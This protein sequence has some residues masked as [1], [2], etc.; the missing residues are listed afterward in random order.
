MQEMRGN[1]T[2][3]EI[4]SQPSTW[5]ETLSYLKK[6]WE[7]KK[8]S[9]QDYDQVIVSGC[10]STYYLSIWAA[11]FLQMNTGI[12]CISLPGSELWYSG[13]NWIKPYQKTLLI[14]VSRS[15]K[16]TETLHAMD[17]FLRSKKGDALAITCYADSPLAKMTPSAIITS[18]GMEHSIAQ[19]RSFTNMMWP[20]IFM[21]S[22]NISDDQI[23]LIEQSARRM[24]ED[25]QSEALRIG[26]NPAFE[27]FFFLGNGP[28]YGLA[29]EVMLKM[30]EMSLS[31]SEAYHFLEFRHGPM[32]MVNDLSLVVGFTDGHSLKFE[33]PVFHDMQKLGA[34]TLSV[35]QHDYS[36]TESHFSFS[37]NGNLPT[38]LSYPL[39]LPLIQLIAY[40]RSISKGLNPDKP[41]NLTA[42]VEL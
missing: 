16:T 17:I 22:E 6:D 40:E 26:N 8:P 24:I 20:I 31:Y 10:G 19:T 27:R 32:S 12:P 5:T 38:H 35:G 9:I 4:L 41:E 11:R 21:G 33:I 25:Y 2:R 30:K 1:F 34:R 23:K 39:Y 3:E 15:G 18:A 7:N 42:V 28:L 29:Q 13:E 37:W 36:S 14:A